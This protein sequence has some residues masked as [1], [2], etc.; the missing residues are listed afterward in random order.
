M[1]FCFY[2]EDSGLSDEGKQGKRPEEN[3]KMI[4]PDT[5]QKDRY[6]NPME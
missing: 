1:F 6:Q 4:Q 5:R 2:E 3:A